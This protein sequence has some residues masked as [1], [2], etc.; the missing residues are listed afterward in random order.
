MLPEYQWDQCTLKPASG[1]IHQ[2][3]G[4][5]FGTRHDLSRSLYPPPPSCHYCCPSRFDRN[6]SGHAPSDPA[7][8]PSLFHKPARPRANFAQPREPLRALGL[9]TLPTLPTLRN[10]S[11]T[12]RTDLIPSLHGNVAATWS[13]CRLRQHPLCRDAN[14]AHLAPRNVQIHDDYLEIR[15]SDHRR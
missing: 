13:S 4:F 9:P 12:R 8:R 7:L 3:Q 5:L 14:C 11:S 10:L 6:Q 2:P 1:R 15:W